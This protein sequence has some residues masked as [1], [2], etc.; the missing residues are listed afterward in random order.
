ML[1]WA[2]SI[3]QVLLRIF[4]EERFKVEDSIPHVSPPVR[5]T[6][7]EG[8]KF[9][10]LYIKYFQVADSTYQVWISKEEDVKFQGLYIKYFKVAE[11][12]YH[13]RITKEEGVKV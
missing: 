9:Q 1:K 5:I 8:V 3:Y 11:F 4:K 10:G 7:E 6:K 12:T 13:V 2:E